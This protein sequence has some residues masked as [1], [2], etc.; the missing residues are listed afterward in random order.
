MARSSLM[1]YEKCVAP[2]F[3][4]LLQNFGLKHTKPYLLSMANAGPDSNGS[5][6]FITV[7]K[8][9]WLDGRHV[10]FGRVSK[11]VDIVSLRLSSAFTIT[12]LLPLH[13]CDSSNHFY[14]V[15]QQYTSGTLYMH[16]S[17][18]L[19][20]CASRKVLNSTLTPEYRFVWIFC[21]V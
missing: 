14:F 5:Q 10:V 12:V 20:F 1:R 18:K 7:A 17:S 9:P 2:L 8:T 11:G 19:L 6:F 4:S 13:S 3:K 16:S 15:K 21:Y